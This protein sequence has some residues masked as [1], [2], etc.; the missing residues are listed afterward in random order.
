[1]LYSIQSKPENYNTVRLNIDIPW[2]CE[3]VKYYVSS[4]NTKANILMTTEDDYLI[5]ETKN[6]E[7]LIKFEEMYNYSYS[8]L[9]NYLNS[10]QKIGDAN[11]KIIEFK[12]I[13]NRN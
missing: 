10:N 8:Y 7:I 2:K 12:N 13:N 5:F 4:I 9:V 11:A 3:F 1:M 6:G